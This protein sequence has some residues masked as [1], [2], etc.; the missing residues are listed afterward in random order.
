MSPHV[1][2]PALTTSICSPAAL[3]PGQQV[4]EG[5]QHALQD[6]NQAACGLASHVV[7]QK[8]EAPLYICLNLYACRGIFAILVVITP[9][10]V[11]I[12]LFPCLV[13]VRSMLCLFGSVKRVDQNSATYSGRAPPPWQGPLPRVTVQMPVFMEDLDFVIRPSVR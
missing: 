1:K 6:A 8:A 13:I 9:V 4:S 10:S 7:L 5:I 2:V 3:C 12:M 11:F